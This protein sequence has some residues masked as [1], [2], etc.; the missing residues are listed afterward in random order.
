MSE[1]AYLAGMPNEILLL[2]FSHLL[3]LNAPLTIKPIHC[4]DPT[5]SI[6]IAHVSKRFQALTFR[7]LY[8]ES[9]FTIDATPRNSDQHQHGYP[10]SYLESDM[11]KVGRRQIQHVEIISGEWLLF[12]R[13]T[14]RGDR[15]LADASAKN[16]RM[17]MSNLQKSVP[18]LERI[19][20]ATKIPDQYSARRIQDLALQA[21][22]SILP[23]VKEMSIIRRIDPIQD[24]GLEGP[25]RRTT[26][27]NF[28][29]NRVTGDWENLF[30]PDS[31]ELLRELEERI[32]IDRCIA[33]ALGLS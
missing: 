18:Q 30:G 29:E 25:I 7:V 1:Q 19:T 27:L 11:F 21:V 17:L 13:F 26:L 24:L 6:A 9:R 31:T 15:E 33:M 32:D 23:N 2:I 10:L 22:W 12:E 14:G 8:K 20:F 3:H 4:K 5:N 28:R 16:V